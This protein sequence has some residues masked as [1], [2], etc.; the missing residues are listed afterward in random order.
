MDGLNLRRLRKAAALTQIALARQAGVSHSRLVA[1]ELGNLQLTH[2]EVGK[3]QKAVA[4]AS[5]HNVA[6]IERAVGAPP[7]AGS[8]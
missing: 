3:I 7:N 8:D 1:A 5:G 4:R 6:Y 2:D